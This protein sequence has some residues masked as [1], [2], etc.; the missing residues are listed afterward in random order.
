MA[1]TK[2]LLLFLRKLCGGSYPLHKEELKTGA[3]IS[4]T[5]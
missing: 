3:Y 4:Q 1:R 5:M 2:R